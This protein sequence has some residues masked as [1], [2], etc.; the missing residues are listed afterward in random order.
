MKYDITYSCGHAGTVELFGKGAEREKK[1]YWYENSGMCP[2]CYKKF[3]REKEKEEGLTVSIVLCNEV[4][5]FDKDIFFV[6]GGDS[7]NYK[8]DIK[9][10]EGAAYTDKYPGKNIFEDALGNNKP[11]RWVVPASINDYEKKLEE[12]EKIAKVLSSPA[13]A[14][15]KRLKQV[16]DLAI[17]QMNEELELL[18]SIP[19]WPEEISIVWP[20]DAKW[21]GKFYGKP[22]QWSVYFDDQGQPISD[23]LK[24][25]MEKALSDRTEWKKQKEKIERKYNNKFPF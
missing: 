5:A 6:F 1:I 14:D 10:L 23:E 9:C 19:P 2:E 12:V 16:K 20:E 11:K 22:G 21:N 15:L 13:E 25:S 18:G 4:T 8:E 17:K 7:Y 24:S 3:I